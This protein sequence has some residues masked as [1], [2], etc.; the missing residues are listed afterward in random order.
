MLPK[1][2]AVSVGRHR[3]SY[4]LPLVYLTDEENEVQKKEISCPTHTQQSWEARPEADLG[5][6]LSQAP[7]TKLHIHS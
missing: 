5:L 2:V 6:G 7:V 3:R 4:L 1:V